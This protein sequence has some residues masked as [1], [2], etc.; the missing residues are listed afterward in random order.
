MLHYITSLITI[1][2][3]TLITFA[4]VSAGSSIFDV[5]RCCATAV[6]DYNV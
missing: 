1:L 3:H 4:L 6:T 2:D 5:A